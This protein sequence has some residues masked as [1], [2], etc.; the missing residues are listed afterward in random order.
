MDNIHTTGVAFA[1]SLQKVLH[2][3]EGFWLWLTYLGDP[4]TVFLLYFPLAY[5]LQKRL[6][7]TVLWLGLICEWLNLVLKWFLFGE[8]PFWWVHESGLVDGYKLRQFP[9][10]CETGP[11]S[12]SGHCMIT[13]AALLPIMM[14]LTSKLQSGIQRHVPLLMYIL[15]MSGIG[16]SRLLIL[17]HF[18]HQVLA[19]ILSGV[20]LGYIL[21]RS[22]PYNR[23][24][25]FYI[26]ASMILLF[27]ALL[28]YWGMSAFGADL[29]WSIHLATKWCSKPEWVRPESRP[30]SSVTRSAGNAMGLGFALCCPLYQK[31]HRSYPGWRV[32]GTILLLS[33][34]FLKIQ[35]SLPLPVFSPFLYYT[36][37]FLRHCLCPLIVIIFTPYLVTGLYSVRQPK[38]E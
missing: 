21:K 10:T 17:A 19:G 31:L 1:G 27:G 15:L 5:A 11:G 6:A 36:L 24:F 29:S 23:S 35:Q 30:F 3:S 37:N 18:P 8:R 14:F 9:S 2:G 13:G 4:G 25:V 38:K 12:P 26:M 20:L 16:I 28:V 33:I 34:F 22:V 7:V 32:R